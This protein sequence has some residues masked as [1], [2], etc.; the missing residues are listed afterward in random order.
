MTDPKTAERQRK[1]EQLL[2]FIG[3]QLAQG[4][5][6]QQV[7]TTLTAKGIPQ[8]IAADLVAKSANHQKPQPAAPAS[9][10]PQTPAEEVPK[11]TPQQPTPKPAASVQ[12]QGGYSKN[13]VEHVDQQLA[14][15]KSQQELVNELIA[16]GVSQNEAIDRVVKASRLRQAELSP[17]KEETTRKGKS[18][19]GVKKMLI[20]IACLVGGGLITAASYASA[21]PG[22]TFSIFYGLII[23]G[24]V[25]TIW[26]LIE[27]IMNM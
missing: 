17:P 16:Q 20:G 19:Q 24:I 25:Y 12:P 11:P 10:R 27:W 15:G 2:T 22:G 4:K 5:S 8:N 18:S 6:H 9:Q 26:G 23:Y 13:L 7:V 3:Q 21:E 14:Q 1:M